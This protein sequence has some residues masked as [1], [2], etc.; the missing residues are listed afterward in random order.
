MSSNVSIVKPTLRPTL[1]QQWDDYLYRQSRAS[2]YRVDKKSNALR[3]LSSVS[4]FVKLFES[5]FWLS[6]LLEATHNEVK[7]KMMHMNILV[8]KNHED[9]STHTLTIVLATAFVIS[10]VTGLVAMFGPCFHGLVQHKVLLMGTVCSFVW[11]I[12]ILALCFILDYYKH[13]QN[14]DNQTETAFNATIGMI[15]AGA[16]LVTAKKLLAKESRVQRWHQKRLQASH[17]R[18]LI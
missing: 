11:N 4:A 8:G 1:S 15:T 2:S 12:I 18:P 3:I 6:L 17:I 7:G 14:K 16:L 13:S 9:N 5:L 10:M